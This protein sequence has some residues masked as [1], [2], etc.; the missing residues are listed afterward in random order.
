MLVVVIAL[1]GNRF[2]AA[3]GHELS[4]NCLQITVEHANDHRWRVPDIGLRLVECYQDRQ[5]FPHQSVAHA[6]A[7]CSPNCQVEAVAHQQLR[8]LFRCINMRLT[9][10]RVHQTTVDFLHAVSEAAGR[11][12]RLRLQEKACNVQ[13]DGQYQVRLNKSGGVLGRQAYG[14]DDFDLLAGCCAREAA[15]SPCWQ[16]MALWVRSL[17]R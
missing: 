10:P 15:S 14:E 7:Q 9:Y 4:M 11:K 17:L 3:P 2:R 1:D 5:K 12:A 13:D 6:L 8:R 16:S